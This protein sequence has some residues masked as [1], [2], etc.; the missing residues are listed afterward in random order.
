MP[1][2]SLCPWVNSKLYILWILLE[3][4]YRTCSNPTLYCRR[5]FC[6]GWLTNLPGINW[7]YSICSIWIRWELTQETYRIRYSKPCEKKRQQIFHVKME[8]SV[9]L[10]NLMARL[11]RRW[12]CLIHFIL[13]SSL[14]RDSR[15]LRISHLD[16]TLILELRKWLRNFILSR[17]VS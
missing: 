5:Y 17:Q 3:I 11:L 9:C 8:I 1:W 14:M 2:T 15:P 10:R 12:I 6:Q 16:L 13:S 7:L 4:H